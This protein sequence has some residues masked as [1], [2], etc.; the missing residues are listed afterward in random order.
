MVYLCNNNNA[1]DKAVSILDS[2]GI[3]IYP[4]DTLYGF[5]VD[6]TN[7]KAIEKL[8]LLKNRKEPLSII[9]SSL[10]EITKYGKLDNEAKKMC[11]Q[12]F[13]GPF[14]VLI[15][16]IDSSLSPLVHK[17]SKYTGVRI[18]NHPFP[19]QLVKLLGK[20]IIT[21][22]V[23]KKGQPAL[24]NISDI[25]DSFPNID[26]FKDKI[27]LSSKGSTIINL[28]LNPYKIIRNGDGVL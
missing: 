22:S 3:I 21:T 27:N 1:I 6:A 16:S 26:I 8:N 28:A 19:I 9:I 12:I 20:P 18:P 5:G 4:T 10:S 15:E 7:S 23:N 17:L 24:N 13:P 14:T 11:N 2:G 25:E